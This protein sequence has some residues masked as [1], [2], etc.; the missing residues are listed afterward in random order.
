[1]AGWR[2]RISP[3]RYQFFFFLAFDGR[4]TLGEMK[5]LS[6]R[7][8][9]LPA[10]A[11]QIQKDIVDNARKLD[12]TYPGSTVSEELKR[13]GV[14]G[15]YLALVAG[16]FGNLSNYF[17]AVASLYARERAKSILES[18]NSKP[19]SIFAMCKH[20]VTCRL[21]LFAARGWAQLILDRNRDLVGPRRASADF[22]F[23]DPDF[24][25]TEAFNF[26]HPRHTQTS[27]RHWAI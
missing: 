4:Q 23:P 26:S 18:R 27:A 10:R 22:A 24:E 21:G 9:S 7:D 16:P 6:R 5:T 3:L 8:I 1:M 19:S 17:V 20:S 12:E 25:A 11:L 15:K 2:C 14:D 13:Y